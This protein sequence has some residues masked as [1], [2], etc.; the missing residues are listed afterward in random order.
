MC[1]RD[2]PSRIAGVN[3]ALVARDYLR[4]HEVGFFPRELTDVTTHVLENPGEYAYR[5]NPKSEAH[6]N[7]PGA[8]AALQVTGQS[9]HCDAH[10]HPI[11]SCRCAQ[12]FLR[13]K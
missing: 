5:S 4:Q 3:M 9:Q 12:F 2:T 6:I 1:F 8:I 7:D 10:V 11:P 13:F